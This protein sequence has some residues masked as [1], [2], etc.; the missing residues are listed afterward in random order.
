MTLWNEHWKHI[1][2]LKVFSSKTSTNVVPPNAKHDRHTE[3]QT[4]DKVIPKWHFALLA[5]QNKATKP[6]IL[7]ETYDKWPYNNRTLHDFLVGRSLIGNY[8]PQLPP[9]L[10]IFTRRSLLAEDTPPPLVYKVAKRQKCDLLQG[11]LHQEIYLRLCKNYVKRNWYSYN[12]IYC[13]VNN[14]S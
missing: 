7:S 6:N 5:T 13:V 12:Y 9:F 14:S 4:M 8:V 11:H 1:E 2:T 3:R 10:V